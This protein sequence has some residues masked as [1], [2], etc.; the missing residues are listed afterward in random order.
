[1][2]DASRPHSFSLGETLHDVLYMLIRYQIC[3]FYNAMNYNL[4][5][6]YVTDPNLFET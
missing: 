2:R 5:Q 4:I 3:C 6:N 1:M